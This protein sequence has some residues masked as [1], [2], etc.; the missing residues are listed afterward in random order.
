MKTLKK[1]EV[2]CNEYKDLKDL[3]M[4]IETFIDRYYNERRL[5]SAIGYRSPMDFEFG[6]GAVAEDLCTAPRMTYFKPPKQAAV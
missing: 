3:R 5:H 4:H 2:Y 6:S 1:E